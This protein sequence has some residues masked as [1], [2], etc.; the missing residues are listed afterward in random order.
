MLAQR[1]DVKVA[2]RDVQIALPVTSLQEEV[3]LRVAAHLKQ[4]AVGTDRLPHLPFE[5]AFLA[6]A[7]DD[8]PLVDACLLKQYNSA[9][10]LH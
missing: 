7:P 8:R 10:R 2:F 3:D 1:R 9:R 5:E 6:A 4:C